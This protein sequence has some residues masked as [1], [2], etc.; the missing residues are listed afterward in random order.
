MEVNDILKIKI[1]FKH[2][3]FLICKHKLQ[4]THKLY[5]IG[6][7]VCLPSYFFFLILKPKV[8]YQIIIM[9]F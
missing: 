7:Y 9:R 5:C 1:D 3:A 4:C 2:M 8:N 6:I